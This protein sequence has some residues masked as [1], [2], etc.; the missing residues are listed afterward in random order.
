MEGV[1]DGFWVVELSVMKLGVFDTYRPSRIL[2]N[3]W[4]LAN[5]AS[6]TSKK[7]VYHT[8]LEVGVSSSTL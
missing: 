7:T 2:S 6:D 4:D 8:P 3:Q 5:K 1:C